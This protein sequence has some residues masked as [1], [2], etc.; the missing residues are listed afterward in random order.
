VSGGDKLG[1]TSY[2]VVLYGEKGH[3][4]FPSYDGCEI[5]EGLEGKLANTFLAGEYRAPFTVPKIV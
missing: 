1:G 3:M 2:G 4:T 5:F